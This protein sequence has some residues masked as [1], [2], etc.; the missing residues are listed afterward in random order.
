MP[1][2]LLYS[3]EHAWVRVEGGGA[4]VGISGFAQSELGEIAFVELPE[5][6]RTVRA[7]EPV[8]AVDSLKSTSELTAPLSGTVTAVNGLLAGERGGSLVNDDPTGRGWLYALSLSDRR[9][10]DSL[11]TVA[12]Y[13]RYVAGPVP[14]EAPESRSR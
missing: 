7:G 4:T 5:I 9:E 6:G 1:G 3:E 8:A 13:E 10:L 11:M 2:E 12:Q 14:G